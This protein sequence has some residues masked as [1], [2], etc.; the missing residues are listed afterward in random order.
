[1]ME[2]KPPFLGAAYYPED[3]DETE[4]D[5]D[6]EK[7]LSVG[8][9][10]ARIGEFAWRKMEPREGEFDF[11]WLHNVVDKL[12]AAGIGVV[13]G[14]PTATPPIWLTKKYP[15]MFVEYKNGRKMQHSGRRHACSNHPEYLKYSARIVEKLAAEF[16][17]DEAIIGWQIDNEIYL[18][19]ME[20][21]F[22]PNCHKKYQEHLKRKFGTVE[23]MNRRLNLDLFSQGYDSFDEVPLPRDTWENPHLKQEF[24]ISAG[25]ANI[26]FVAMQAAILKKYTNAPI[27]TD[28]I[29]FNGMNYRKLHAPLDLV[30]FNHYNTPEDLWESCLWFDYIRTMKDRPFWNTETATCF[31]GSTG[32]SGGIKPDGFC[33][34]NSWLP[35]ALG[36]E[37]NM[38]WLWRTHWAGHELVHGSVLDSSGRPMYSTGEVTEVANDFRKCAD[39]INHTTVKTKVALHYSSLCWNMFETQPVVGEFR[40]DPN[41]KNRFYKPLIHAGLRPDVID[42]EADLSKYDVVFSPLMI[43]LDQGDLRE[44]ITEWVKNGGIWVTGPMTDIRTKDGTRYTD[45]LHGMLETLTP[46]VFK[47]WFPDHEKRV[48]G[49]WRDGED[50][51]GNTYYEIFEPNDAADLVTVTGGHKAVTGGAVLQGFPVGKGF[52]YVLGTLPDEKDMLKL[53][54]AVCEKAK[55]EC[56]TVTGDSL[57]VSPR[58]G[59]KTSGVILVDVCGKG[60]VYYNKAGYKDIISGKVF[61]SDIP[62]EPYGV[63]VL[64]KLK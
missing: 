41:L 46:A 36:G 2:L 63:L 28:Q 25:Q 18:Q 45:R 51:S 39:F 22:C 42:E 10:V 59:E 52:V 5:R 7:M 15:D 9:N 61:E 58:K 20:G 26:D 16:G 40:Y 14:T 43:T 31:C 27:G 12:R 33:Y 8:I 62:V 56:R 53:I 32:T 19:N 60:G 57:I 34:V 44:R 3:W 17:R 6:I 21:C 24:L 35:V 64:E 4:I 49:Q 55:I 1:M 23:E 37:A 38:Y 48:T 54:S 30:Q 11:S 13:M 29:P 47:Y 50:F